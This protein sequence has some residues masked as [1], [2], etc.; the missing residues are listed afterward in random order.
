M[1]GHSTDHDAKSA[2]G[3]L[4]VQPIYAS[5]WFTQSAEMESWRSQTTEIIVYLYLYL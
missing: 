3:K 5:L 1:L 4:V 2:Q